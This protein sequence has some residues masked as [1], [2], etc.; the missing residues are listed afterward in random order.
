MRIITIWTVL[1]LLLASGGCVATTPAP[2][3]SGIVTVRTETA[4]GSGVAVARDMKSYIIATVAHVIRYDRNPSV[5]RIPGKLVAINYEMDAALVRVPDRGQDYRIRDLVTPKQGEFITALGW[6]CGRNREKTV[7]LC[8]RGYVVSLRWLSPAG[9][10]VA[11]CGGFPGMS[12]GAVVN[13]QGECIG[14]I[15]GCA[16]SGP[17][18]LLDSTV[19]VIPSW[20]LQRLMAIVFKQE[21]GD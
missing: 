5:D 2:D 9:R 14:V 15:S 20:E 11:N 16:Q 19:F 13:S 8:Y 7:Q 3:F 21:S 6:T 18:T 12:G 17:M 4:F 10:L 1:L